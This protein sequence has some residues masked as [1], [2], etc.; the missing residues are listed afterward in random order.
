MRGL[1]VRAHGQGYAIRIKAVSPAFFFLLQSFK[2]VGLLTR[3]R[4]VQG[5]RGGLLIL[6]SF[7][8]PLNLASGG[9]LAAPPLICNCL[10][11][12]F[13]NSGK[14]MEAGVLPTRNGEQ[15]GLHAS[16]LHRA[17]LGFTS[18]L[19]SWITQS[20]RV[21][22]YVV[23]ELKKPY[24]D[25]HM[26]TASPNFPAT[27]VSHLGITSFNLTEVLTHK[28]PKVRTTQLR[29]CQFIDPQKLCE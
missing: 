8:G 1:I 10:N 28:S 4:C 26:T 11:L 29:C 3:L 21:R 6:M 24:R 2:R 18:M 14:V 22:C 5:L 9:F 20:G 7:S 23:R 13:G 17:P 12:P 25:V 19:L 16:E 27:V 15:K